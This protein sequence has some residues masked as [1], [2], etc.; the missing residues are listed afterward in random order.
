MLVAYDNYKKARVFWKYCKRDITVYFA[1][2]VTY[3]CIM[4]M[5][6]DPGKGALHF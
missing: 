3:R 4:F 2:I 6:L 1:I 5:K